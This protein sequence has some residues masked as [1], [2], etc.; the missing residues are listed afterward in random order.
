MGEVEKEDQDN[1]VLILF[2]ISGQME[3]VRLSRFC[4]ILQ[5]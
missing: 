1:P 5:Q 2:H 4:Y 3:T